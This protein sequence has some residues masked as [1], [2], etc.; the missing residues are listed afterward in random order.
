M[1][2]G[3]LV[4]HVVIVRQRT[5]SPGRMFLIRAGMSKLM[6]KYGPSLVSDTMPSIRTLANL[7]GFCPF[8]AFM[9]A[10]SNA[11]RIPAT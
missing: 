3:K 8:G 9:S 11:E 1:K 7:T 10:S 2:L 4:C 5:T 6:T